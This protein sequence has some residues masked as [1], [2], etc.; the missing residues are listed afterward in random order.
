MKIALCLYGNVGHKEAAG[1]RIKSPTYDSLQE[2]TKPKN[3]WLDPIHAYNKFKKF[4][5]DPHD[6]DV[7]IHSWSID[8]KEDLVEMYKPAA[9]EIVRQ[10][11]FDVDLANYGIKSEDMSKW[12]ISES[13]RKGYELLLPSRQTVSN[14]MNDMETLAF[15]THSR[16]WSN[17]RV[18]KLKRESLRIYDFV[19]VSRLDNLFLKPIPF[20]D[21]DPEKFYGSRRTGRED[22]D[23]AL[24][25]YWF[26]GGDS[27]MEEFGG[28]YNNI[29]EYCIRPTFACREHAVAM[30]ADVEYLFEH[31]VDYKLLRNV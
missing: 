17:K 14:I 19:V 23:Y 20:D 15:R 26:I 7:Y 30:G 10:K 25:D 27:V 21:L 11:Y 24:F 13:A 9:H 8:H 16:W 29:F 4:I 28:L 22:I 5:I 31:N 1:V 6:T 2:S 3:Q 18:L 12:Q